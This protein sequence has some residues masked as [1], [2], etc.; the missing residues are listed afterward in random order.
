MPKHYKFLGQLTEMHTEVGHLLVVETKRA[1]K[2][3]SWNKVPY[4]IYSFS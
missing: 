3:N 2:E 1:G 4:E